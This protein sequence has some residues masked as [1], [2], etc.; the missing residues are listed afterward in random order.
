MLESNNPDWGEPTLGALRG[1]D[2]LYVADAQWERYGAG[3]A[4]QGEGRAAADRD[5]RCSGH[6]R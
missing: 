3:G 1:D 6:R 2:F 4:L 5:P